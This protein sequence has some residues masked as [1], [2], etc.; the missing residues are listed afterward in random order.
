[1]GRAYLYEPVAAREAYS[2]RLMSEA[3]AESDDPAATLVRFIGSMSAEETAALH[4]ALDEEKRSRRRR[5]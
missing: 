3:F 4:Q 5:R 2:A 1:H